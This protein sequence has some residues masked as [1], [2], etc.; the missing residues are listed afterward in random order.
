MRENRYYRELLDKPK[1]EFVVKWPCVKRA[2]GEFEEF[3]QRMANRLIF[4][5]FRYGSPRRGQ[6][7]HS[8]LKE[9]IKAYTKTGNAENLVNIA[10]YCHLEMVAPE[11]KKFHFDNT[12]ESATRKKFGV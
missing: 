1:K 12:V 9:E 6:R 5:E 3:V 4:G 10:N 7:Y 8:R 11:H 2:P